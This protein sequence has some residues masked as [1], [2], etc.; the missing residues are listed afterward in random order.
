[1]R[2]SV[3]TVEWLE[4]VLH[5]WSSYVIVPIFALANA[6]IV[7]STHTMRAAW[8]SP[9]MWG[10][11][12]GLFVGKPLGVLLASA[13]ATRSG[14]ADRPDDTTGRQMFGAGT[15]AGI[16]F[17]VALFI[18]ELAFTSGTGPDG[19]AIVDVEQVSDAKMAILAASVL[20]GVVAFLVLRA[21]PRSSRTR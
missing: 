4:H 7:V 11:F 8:H 21:R 10:V 14:I 17:T 12:V 19:R 3:S 16:G 1:M 2:S 6:G 9:I 18:A 20:S 15:A 5:P 13:L